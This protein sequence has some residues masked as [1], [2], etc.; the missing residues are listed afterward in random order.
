VALTVLRE[1][2]LRVTTRLFVFVDFPSSAAAPAADADAGGGGP[3]PEAGCGAPAVPECTRRWQLLRLYDDVFGLQL[4]LA[5]G[6]GQRV[7]VVLLPGQLGAVQVP[8]GGLQ[9][10]WDVLASPHVETLFGTGLREEVRG[11][12]PR[13]YPPLAHTYPMHALT[14]HLPQFPRPCKCG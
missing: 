6:G 2:L 7:D 14:Q 5:E 10:P 13:P 3:A 4:E 11:L 1:C 8:L 9:A 12:S